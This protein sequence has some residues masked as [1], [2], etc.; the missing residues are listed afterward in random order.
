MQEL[1]ADIPKIALMPESKRDVLKVLDATLEMTKSYGDTPIITM[2]MGSEGVISRISGELFGS[3]VTFGSLE[4]ASAPG[5][6]NVKELSQL[7][8]MLH[9]RL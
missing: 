3:A 6:I 9:N 5:Q 2:S 1:G 4:K 8:D 7:L